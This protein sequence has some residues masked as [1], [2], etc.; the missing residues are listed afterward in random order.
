MKISV[1]I[2]SYNQREV[3]REAIDS[4]VQQTLPPCQIIV[5]DDC[6]H[7]GSQD[8]IADYAREHGNLFTPIYHPANTG[9]AQARIDALQAVRGDYVTY[10][11]G[12]DR[13]LPDKLK[14]EARTLQESPDA[15][16]A[17]SNNAYVTEDGN[18][19]IYTWIDGESPPQGDVFCQTFARAFPRDSLFRMELVRYEDWK[20]IGF[21]DPR[22]RIYEDYDMRV[23]LTKQLKVTYCDQVLSEIR[24]HQ[25]GLSHS[26]WAVHFH[27]LNVLYRKNRGLLDDLDPPAR[28]QALHMFHT[29]MRYV[30]RGALAAAVQRRQWREALRTARGMLAYRQ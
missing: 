26:E 6:S 24:W 28:R 18:E 1:F 4:V 7:D 17:F 21:H 13:Y 23:R 5:V 12:D 8:L 16:I 3:L 14:E 22:F 10:L 29:T 25:A 19:R 11:D 30:G 20:R 15:R 9:V 2:T 27:W